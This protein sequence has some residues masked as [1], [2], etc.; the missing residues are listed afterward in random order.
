MALRGKI[1][2]APAEIVNNILSF[3]VHPRSRLP[4]RTEYQ[5]SYDCPEAE[6]KLAK[7][8]YYLQNHTSPPDVDRYGARLFDYTQLRHPLNALALTSRFFLKT[9]EQYCEHLLRVNKVFNLPYPCADSRADATYPNMSGIVYRRL[10]L[11]WAPRHCLFCNLPMS[12]YPHKNMSRSPLV[13]CANCYY[14]QA[15]VRL[16]ASVFRL[17]RWPSLLDTNSH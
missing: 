8:A 17:L 6:S 15:L 14:A 5:S 4:G 3:L 11:Q 12:C 16:T 10:W 9:V 1:E 7:E 2:S 13:V